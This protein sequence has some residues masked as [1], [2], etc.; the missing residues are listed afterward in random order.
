MTRRDFCLECKQYC[1]D[2]APTCGRCGESKCDTCLTPVEWGVY[3]T[4]YIKHINCEMREYPLAYKCS[5][6]NPRMAHISAFVFNNFNNPRAFNK[7]YNSFD[8]FEDMAKYTT[9]KICFSANI[10][11]ETLGK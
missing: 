3:F 9:K 8:D 5:D 6:T 10:A 2:D 4:N 1:G 11:T 7:I